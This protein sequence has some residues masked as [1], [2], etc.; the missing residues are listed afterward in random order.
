MYIPKHFENKDI[1]EV[2]SFI[3]A[4]SFGI[5]ISTVDGRP[6]GS[7]IP[8]ELEKDMSDKDTIYGHVSKANPQW[9]NFIED[10]E[11]LIIYN[12]PHSYI[13][14][15]WYSI[16]EVPTWNYIAVH[17][18]GKLKI[19]GE[20]ELIYSLEKLM[21][22]YER[23]SQNPVKM[24]DLSEKTM[25]Q[26]NGIVGFRIDITEIQAAYKLSQN[27]SA[28]DHNSIVDQL[29]ARNQDMDTSVSE[30]MRKIKD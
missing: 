5:L 25:K 15:S 10:Q 8:L 1:G 17:V 14:S 22:K 18:Y 28:Q 20:Q 19:I 16:E 9:K 26:L 12:G 13:S 4:N 30:C 11:V 7:H 23:D 6:W 24:E 3:A 2:K 27:R 29:H 21:S